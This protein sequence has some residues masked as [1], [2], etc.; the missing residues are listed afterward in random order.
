M[1]KSKEQ[2]LVHKIRNNRDSKAFQDLYNLFTK[3]IYR[4]I[5][6]RVPGKE[7]ALDIHQE[8]FLKLWDYI[9]SSERDIENLSALIY[10]ITQNLI[11]AYYV[12]QDLAKT[13]SEKDKIELGLVDYKIEDKEHS[14]E[15][16]LNLKMEFQDLKINLEK[17][18]PKEYREIIELRFFQDLSH[19]EIS[20]FLEKTEG[21]VKVLLHR[22]IKKLRSIMINNE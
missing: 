21:S 22:A 2:K 19:K 13:V 7:E 12:K 8:V 9:I 14:I 10:K 20:K 3:K 1:I 17:L 6:S 4:K 16:N 11:A 5:F 15:Y 18:E